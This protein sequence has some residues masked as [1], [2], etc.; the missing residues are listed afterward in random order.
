MGWKDYR[1]AL[2]YLGDGLERALQRISMIHVG[3]AMEGEHDVG[4]GPQP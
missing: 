2:R 1:E 3:G 4:F